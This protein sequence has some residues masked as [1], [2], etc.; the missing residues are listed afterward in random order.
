[1]F[2]EYGVPLIC[3]F[4]YKDRIYNSVLMRENTGQ[5]TSLFCNLC[6][7]FREKAINQAKL[8]K[9]EKI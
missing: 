7:M 4:P 1:M 3:I 9:A 6:K 8:D 5:I 2:S